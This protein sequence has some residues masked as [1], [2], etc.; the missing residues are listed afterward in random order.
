MV[1]SDYNII[2]RSNHRQRHIRK[3]EKILLS[4]DKR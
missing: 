1:E 4:D 2:K 3:A